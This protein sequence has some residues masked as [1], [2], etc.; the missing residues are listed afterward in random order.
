MRRQE[1]KMAVILRHKDKTKEFG[2]MGD[3]FE[4]NVFLAGYQYWKDEN[5]DFTVME[6]S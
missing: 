3:R 4:P 5:H 2:H 1:R 6:I